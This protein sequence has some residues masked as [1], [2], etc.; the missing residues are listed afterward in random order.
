MSGKN[1]K[2]GSSRQST[3][4]SNRRATFDYEILEKFEV[5]ISLQGSEVKSLRAGKASLDEA[6][7]HISEGQLRLRD[8]YI[9]TYPQAGYAQHEPTRERTLL[10]HRREI[11]KLEAKATQRGWTLIPLSLY[12]NERGL[13]KLQLALVRG[14]THEDKRSDIKEREHKREMARAMKRR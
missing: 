1:T 4:I 5:G 2:S 9:N 13:V 12:F 7:A 3:R 10:A 6:W 14:K 11:K 8:F